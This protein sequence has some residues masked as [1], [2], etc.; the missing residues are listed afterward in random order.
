MGWID[1]GH[2]LI[3]WGSEMSDGDGGVEGTQGIEWSENKDRGVKLENDSSRYWR[4][5][6]VESQKKNLNLKNHVELGENQTK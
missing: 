1:R 3:D 6:G 5:N 2:K 4:L